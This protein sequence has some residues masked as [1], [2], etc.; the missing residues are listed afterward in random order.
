MLIGRTDAEVETPIL[1]PPDEKNWLIE[2]DPDTGKDWRQEEKGMTE[3]EMVGWH[4]WLNGHE[5]EKTQGVGDGHGGLAC[6][7]PWVFKE[8]DTTEWLNWTELFGPS[9]LIS[10]GSANVSVVF[11]YVRKILKASL[12]CLIA[13][14]CWLAWW[15]EIWGHISSYN[16]PSQ[17]ASHGSGKIPRRTRENRS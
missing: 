11:L 8:S 4:H 5:F 14:G 12:M 17:F 10:T 16:K 1:W 9:W 7:S 2:K 3:D 15:M 6:C 13:V